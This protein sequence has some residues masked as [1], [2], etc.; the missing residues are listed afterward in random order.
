[1]ATIGID[2][3]TTNSVAA[4]GGAEVKVLPSL[5]NE[6]FTPSVVSFAKRRGAAQ[7]E[8]VVGRSALNNA[9]RDP[10]N[11]VLSIKRLMGRVY[12]EDRVN[13]VRDRFNHCLADPP[14]EHRDDQSVR[15]L[16]DE[17]AYTPTE[18]SA[19]ILRQVKAG[20]ELALGENVTHAVITVPAY[21][22]ERQ[23]KATAEAGE[24]AGLN[25]LEIIDEPTAA[26]IA[27]G[28]GKEDQRH[29]V[30]VYDLGGG[31]FDI[32]I[33]QMTAGQYGVLEIAGNNWLGG[34]DF[35]ATIVKRMVEWVKEEYS[36]DPST[37]IVFLTKSKGEAE[38][39]KIALG[40]QQSYLIS[41]P[42]MFRIPDIGPVDLELEIT[43]EEFENDIRPL[44]DETINLVKGALA[45]QHLEPEDITEVLLVGGS[46]AVPLVQERLHE[47]FGLAKVRRHINPMECV[48][49]GAAIRAADAALNEEAGDDLQQVPRTRVQGVTPQHLGIAAVRGDNPDAFV[50]IIPKGTPYPL[51]E[52]KRRVF[53]PSE[54][55]QTLIRVPVYEGLNERASL[56]EQQGV[57]EFPLP[58]GVGAATPIEVM[59]NYDA[60]RLTTVTIRVV[61]TEQSYTETLKRDRARVRPTNQK[62]NLI[63]D[64]QEEL[65][66]SIR[67]AKFFVE[68][69]GEYASHE[70]R[71]EAEEAIIQG[72]EA[73]RQGNAAKGQSAT[74]V[75]RNKI[76]GSG[77]AS[78]LFVA[79]R[80]M[81]GLPAET[82]QIL[83]QAVASLRTA[84]ARG[85]EREVE[86][87]SGHLRASVAQLM[88]QRAAVPQINDRGSYN[89]LLVDRDP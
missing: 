44:V 60:N 35:D 39:A 52:P 76:L 26:S 19:M 59:F 31:T 24:L 80:A 2:L 70:D 66:P 64:W 79:E 49:L 27:F 6:T 15:V 61:G 43:R 74:L 68:T 36:Y 37:D 48:A 82:S 33:V 9:V 10:A 77:T 34:D 85:N 3:G 20:A 13:E 47:V 69:Y 16:L 71:Q 67:A 40:V 58:E 65:Q 63:D 30:L 84:H 50:P 23:R 75:L 41:A 32:S 83:A 87:L 29:R 57:L 22:E 53:Y 18:I 1:M 55:N 8:I 72:E 28:F 62:Q 42:L 54:E 51:L 12:G 17:T 89:D 86:Q 4:I 81:Q 73:L 7:G 11:T 21:F 25:V 38:R 5:Q 88:S 56:N 14:E 46:T 45:N 78:L